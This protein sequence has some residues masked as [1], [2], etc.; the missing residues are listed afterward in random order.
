[1]IERVCGDFLLQLVDRAEGLGLLGEFQRGA[2]CGDCA[3]V[4]FRFRHQR[5]RL[6]GLLDI[7]G[8]EIAARQ[9][10]QRGDVARVLLQ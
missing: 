6:L 8:G 5:Q 7:A 1:M 10:R 9:A 2:R 3:V 4:G